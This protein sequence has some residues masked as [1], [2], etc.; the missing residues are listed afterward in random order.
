MDPRTA[1]IITGGALVALIIISVT[2]ITCFGILQEYKMER[3]K[4][5]KVQE[6]RG[7]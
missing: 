3:L 1:L 7:S 6:K 2:V 4:R 5:E